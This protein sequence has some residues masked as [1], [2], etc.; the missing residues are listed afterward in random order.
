MPPSGKIPEKDIAALERWVAAG[1]H[2]PA[3]VSFDDADLLLV[4]PPPVA[5]ALELK[6]GQDPIDALLDARMEREGVEPRAGGAA[7][8]A[9][10]RDLRPDRSPPTPEEVDAFLADGAPG[11]KERVVG[12]LLASP[13]FGE[14]WARR[15]PDLCVTPR[16]RRTS[17]TIW[18]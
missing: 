5:P 6:D 7:R 9:P 1:A 2:L 12:R 3:E 13:D 14:R 4:L 16:R 17:S 8:L 18:A 15:W 10:P 11:A